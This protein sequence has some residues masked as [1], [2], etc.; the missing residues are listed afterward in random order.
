MNM[1]ASNTIGTFAERFARTPL[2]A[3]RRHPAYRALL[4]TLAVA[5]AGRNEVAVHIAHDYARTL[6]SGTATVWHTGETLHT[7]AAAWINGVAAHVLD[8]DDV[9]TMMRGHISVAM[10]PALCALAQMDGEKRGAFAFDAGR[11]VAVHEHARER[12]GIDRV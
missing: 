2:T 7:E 1:S 11:G 10:V 5:I 4:D 12:H 6:G 3:A 9:M 8:Y